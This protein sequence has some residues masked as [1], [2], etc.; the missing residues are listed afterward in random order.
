VGAGTLIRRVTPRSP[1]ELS[2][3]KVQ[4]VVT[5]VESL[6]ISTM[7]EL[8]MLVRRHE[9]GDKVDLTVVRSGV[10]RHMR[11]RLVGTPGGS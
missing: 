4:D 3:L 8:M 11:V 7:N 6:P 10:T 1:A 5:A 9:P 2:G